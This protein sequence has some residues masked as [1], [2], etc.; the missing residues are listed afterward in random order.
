M[1]KGVIRIPEKDLVTVEDCYEELPLGGVKTDRD[2]RKREYKVLLVSCSGKH[3]VCRDIGLKTA[4]M[5][6]DD[7]PVEKIVFSEFEIRIYL[8]RKKVCAS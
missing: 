3:V 8:R 1:A 7:Y 4:R 2:G 5:C 6:W